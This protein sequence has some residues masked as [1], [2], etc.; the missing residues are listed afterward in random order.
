M[1]GPW[2]V[3]TQFPLLYFYAHELTGAVIAF[4][5]GPLFWLW[6]LFAPLFPNKKPPVTRTILH[7]LVFF[8]KSSWGAEEENLDLLVL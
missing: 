7:K 8:T 1:S 4:F 5:I 2:A 3:C 6:S